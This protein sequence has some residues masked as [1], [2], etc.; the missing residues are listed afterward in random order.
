MATKEPTDSILTE[1]T[2]AKCSRRKFLQIAGT[3]AAT[4]AFAG[5]P[6]VGQKLKTITAAQAEELASGAP[7]WI[8][9]CC[10]GCG[11]QTGIRVLVENGIVKKIEPNEFNPIGVANISTDY[12][13]EKAR[14]G[15]MCPKGNSA[16]KSLYDPDRLKTPVR[17]VGARGEG[18][19]EPITWD[20]A[21]AEVAKRLGEIKQ[22]YG[23][24]ALVWFS[25]DHSF[26]HI[27]SDFCTAYGTPNYLNHSNLCDVA[28]KLGYK[29]VMGD[30][31][32]LADFQNSKYTLLFGWNPLGATKWSHLPA[33]VNRGR[34][35]GMKLVVV[36]PV[37]SATAA[38]AN[39]WIPIRP[40]TDGAMALAMGN[41]I[42]NEKLY[43]EAFVK[44][45][46]VGFDE[47]S[48]FVKDKT[49]EWAEKITSVPAD[50]IRRIA[51]ELAATKPS[52]IDAWSGP[53]HHSNGTQGTRAVATLSA[54]LGQY[55]KPG[56]MIIPSRKG[57]KARGPVDGW[58]TT[59]AKGARI[60]GKGTKYPFGHG[61]GIYVEAREAMITGQPYQPKAAVFVFQNWV[62]SVPNRAKN[63]EAVKNM[64]FV[65]SV[66][67][68][69]SETAEMADIV[70]PGTHPL[71][72]YDLTSNWITFPAL[73][74]RQPA[75]KSWVNGM[76][77][78]DFVMAVARKMGFPGFDMTYE[79][80]LD[81]E[82]KGGLK[83]GLADLKALPGAVLI[84]GETKY[85]KYAA[86]ITVPDGATTTDMGIIK[87][88]SGK[89][90][91]MKKG[92]K[93]VRGFFTPSGKTELYSKQFKDK[94][95]DPNPAYTDPETKPGGD[96]NLYLVAWKQSEHTHTRTF[97]N[98]WLMEMKSDNPLLMNTA[99]A[100]KLDLKDGDEVWIESP[101]AKAKST[102][103]LTE[104]IHPEVVG[105]QHGFGH[106]AFGKIAKGKGT[107]D[108][109]FCAGKAELASGQAVTKEIAVKVYK[110]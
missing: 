4:A 15:R 70:V 41:V 21:I 105:L 26:T 39:E 90:I 50:T 7:K 81:A 52:V 80:Y 71:E 53:G 64:E 27:Q 1:I 84:G 32:P 67:T 51:R 20:E 73:S 13:R 37:F 10:N 96:Y 69:L 56:T 99:T 23:A 82:L 19:W 59:N 89:Q 83:I 79:D 54:L 18:K 68:H 44:E 94:G 34:Q 108:G 9:T 78:V 72:R 65:L 3:A 46:V 31:R 17:R 35:N 107:D 49:P 61:S 75:V 97:N 74:L 76:S 47:Y 55:D 102:V 85:E 33:I 48:S 86:E 58:D 43:D 29:L 103:Q 22:K 109:Q 11:G 62:M 16:V 106:W 40:G 14:G 24:Q 42:V 60:D 36:D 12:A 87:D 28:R 92:D 77:E 2:C 93:S 88:A 30:D 110:A 95:F 66:D 104:G 91:G 6:I 38:K 101:A 8:Y 57:E 25:E 45:W 98:A 5:I 63:L 100:K